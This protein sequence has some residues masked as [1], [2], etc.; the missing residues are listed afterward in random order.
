MRFFWKILAPILGLFLAVK[1]VP[2]VKV[3]LIPGKS[4]YFGFSFTHQWQ[5]IIFLGLIL[6][7]FNIFLKPILNLIS[8]PLKIL[9]FG[10]FSLILNLAFLWILDLIFPELKFANFSSLFLTMLI[11]LALDFLL[12]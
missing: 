3:T 12:R 5:M 4:V 10:L 2:G 9:T 8:L 7:L 6:G 1:F 11:I